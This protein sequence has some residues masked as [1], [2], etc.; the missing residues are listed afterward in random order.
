MGKKSRRHTKK[1]RRPST[2]IEQL[3]PNRERE[4]RDAERKVEG[5]TVVEDSDFQHQTKGGVDIPERRQSRR[6]R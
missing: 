5:R 4:F 3:S 6:M 2:P 1:R